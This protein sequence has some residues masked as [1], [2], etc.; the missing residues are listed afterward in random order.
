MDVKE[1]YFRLKDLWI[2]STGLERENAG[3]QLDVFMTSLSEEDKR[4]VTE[5]IADDFNRIHKIVD[6]SKQLRKRIEVRKQLEEVLSFISVSEFA[7]TY[8]G[9]SASWLHQRIN[10]NEVH[11]KAA[12]FT[13][14]EL[15]QLADALNDVGDK[16]KRAATAFS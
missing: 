14:E 4:L 5:A 7:K 6:E 10:G 11:G 15:H 13:P 12:T 16:L 1:E 2:K 8:F 9:K 3:K